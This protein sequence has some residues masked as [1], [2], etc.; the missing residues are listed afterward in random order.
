MAD[1]LPFPDS[2]CHSCEERRYVR[3]VRG[4]FILCLVLP[5]KY[6]PQ[7][8][9]ACPRFIRAEAPPA[10]RADGGAGGEGAAG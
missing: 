2:Q 9:R 8:M 7:P 6:P 3:S 10:P 1:A 4:A 5:Q